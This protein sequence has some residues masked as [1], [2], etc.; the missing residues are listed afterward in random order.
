MNFTKITDWEGL[1]ASCSV[2]SLVTVLG[3]E[4]Q[5]WAGA[6]AWQSGS[7]PGLG[8]RSAVADPHGA[9]LSS[10]ASHIRVC[11]E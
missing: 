4:R 2:C 7:L 3:L 9:L 6:Q 10:H 11:P 5:T 1:C 8:H